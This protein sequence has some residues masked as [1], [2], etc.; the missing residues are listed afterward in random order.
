[1]KNFTE[2]AQTGE[3]DHF[4]D[5]LLVVFGVHQQFVGFVHAKLQHILLRCH[6]GIIAHDAAQLRAAVIGKAQKCADT[7]GEVF[8]LGH[9]FHGFEKTLRNVLRK[10]WNG[11]K[12]DELQD[13]SGDDLRQRKLVFGIQHGDPVQTAGK[14]V[15]VL[16]VQLQYGNGFFIED[17]VAHIFAV[18]QDIFSEFGV[19]YRKNHQ[20]GVC[21]LIVER[22]A[23]TRT[24]NVHYRRRECHWNVID[25]MDACAVQTD[26][27]FKEI[28]GVGCVLQLAAL[29]ELKV[30]ILG[31]KEYCIR[32]M[33]D[34]GIL[35]CRSGISCAGTG[36]QPNHRLR[37][38]MAVGGMD[39]RFI[40]MAVL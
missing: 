32:G 18:R 39:K 23:V 7:F 5:G 37:L 33:E 12:E 30:I 40:S 21:G 19:S 31:C 28:M 6:I 36:T 24:Q 20:I 22:V 38:T 13:F 1:M 17:Q 25:P 35:F 11:I 10:N 29:G 4:R 3:T 9:L 8:R 14:L 2:M 16:R 15:A 34:K 26:Y 27:D